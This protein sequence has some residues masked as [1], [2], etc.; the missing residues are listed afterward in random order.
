MHLVRLS[1]ILLALF[2]SHPSFF[3]KPHRQG[4]SSD[5]NSDTI[6]VEAIVKADPSI[7]TVLRPLT[8][9]GNAR[10]GAA[11]SAPAPSPDPLESLRVV[12]GSDGDGSGSQARAARSPVDVEPGRPAAADPPL[13]PTW[14]TKRPAKRKRGRAARTSSSRGRGGSEGDG[15]DPDSPGILCARSLVFFFFCFQ[16]WGETEGG[17]WCRNRFTGISTPPPPIPPI[18]NLI[19]LVCQ[20]TASCRR[21]VT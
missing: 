21:W 10:G 7:F 6:I 2:V 5:L 4:A 14:M 8:P 16:P 13:T 12:G 15:G 18:F 3:L 20:T 19:V 11:G 17:S 9:A 1:T